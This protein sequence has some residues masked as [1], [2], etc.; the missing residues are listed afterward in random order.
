MAWI[1]ICSLM[2]SVSSLLIS[3]SVAWFRM[4]PALYACYCYWVKLEGVG[5]DLHCCLINA[6]PGTA[7]AVRLSTDDGFLRVIPVLTANMEEIVVVRFARQGPPHRLRVE[8]R[9]APFRLHRHDVS[10]N[11]DDMLRTPRPLRRSDYFDSPEKVMRLIETTA[12]ETPGGL[13][14]IG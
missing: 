3:A 14:R 6:G 9:T 5:A 2:L 1:P 8:W 4:R 13:T 7:W 12:N 10:L 11:V